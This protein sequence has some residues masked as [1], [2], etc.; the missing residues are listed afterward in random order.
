[1]FGLLIWFDKQNYLCG[2]VEDYSVIDLGLLVFRSQILIFFLFMNLRF[3]WYGI[4]NSFKLEFDG[5]G[6]V[7]G[8]SFFFLELYYIP[9]YSTGHINFIFNVNVNNYRCF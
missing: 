6:Y 4:R 5:G 9:R 1:M 7:F 2:F 8:L 3:L